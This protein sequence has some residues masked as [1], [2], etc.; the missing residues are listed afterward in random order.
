MKKF[1]S[2]LLTLILCLSLTAPAVSYAATVKLN[3]SKL[4]LAVGDTYSLKLN[5]AS[6]NITWASSK[7]SVAAVNSKGKITA[8][9]EGKATI[10]ATAKNKKYKCSV[11][12]KSNKTIDVIFTAYNF[13]DVS[14]N[15]YAK[16]YKKD[17]PDYIDVK[18]YDD[19]H[20]TVTMYEADRL[21][22][23]KEFND[24]FSSYL[25]SV[26]LEDTYK[27]V[28]TNIETDELIQNVKIYA[29]KK[30]YED[31]FAEITA[32]L[33]FAIVSDTVQAMNLIEPKNRTC[34]ITIYDSI[35]GDILYTS[36][37]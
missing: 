1:I 4:E 11:T 25:S 6:G 12:V 8:V 9:R 21:K 13:E 3:K 37:E 27:D 2:L 33:I 32:L 22:T 30:E 16:Q 24:N 18:A 31:S 26:I 35:T 5:G 34:N 29:N 14:I 17:N 7:K 36:A 28:F 15:E 23:L 19:E 10:T 20:V